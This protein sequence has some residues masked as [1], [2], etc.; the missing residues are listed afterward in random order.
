M[1]KKEKFIQTFFSCKSQNTS[2]ALAKTKAAWTSVSFV[3][4]VVPR[5][6]SKFKS[7]HCV[8]DWSAFLFKLLL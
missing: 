6:F 7:L 1:D 4:V 8:K 5:R 2:D 3:I